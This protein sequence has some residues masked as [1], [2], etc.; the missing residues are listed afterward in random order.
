[1]SKRMLLAES[2][3]GDQ[4]TEGTI[5]GAAPCSL[6]STSH[7]LKPARIRRLSVHVCLRL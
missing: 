4:A 5:Y 3:A 1:V 6:L 7:Q 2:I